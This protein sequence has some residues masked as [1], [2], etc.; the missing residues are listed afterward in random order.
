M[1]AAAK[2]GPGM[3]KASRL[4]LKPCKARTIAR[5]LPFGRQTRYGKRMPGR[6]LKYPEVMIGCRELGAGC[7]MRPAQETSVASRTKPRIARN[8][9]K[10]IPIQVIV[11]IGE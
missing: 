4:S 10:A 3:A 11:A 7:L 6:K 1:P 5:G 9:E 8:F 2:A